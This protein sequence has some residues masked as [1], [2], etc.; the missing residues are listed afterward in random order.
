MLIELAD[1]ALEACCPA[2]YMAGVVVAAVAGAALFA[3]VNDGVGDAVQRCAQQ[4]PKQVRGSAPDSA[5][6]H[7]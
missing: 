4:P 1:R 5:D 7:V 3:A 6:W 2:E